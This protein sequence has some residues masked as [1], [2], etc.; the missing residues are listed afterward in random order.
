MRYGSGTRIK[1]LEAFAHRI[2]VVSTTVGA[3]GLDVE[4]ERELL[5]ADDPAEF[6][7]ACISVLTDDDLRRRLVVNGHNRWSINHQVDVL[8]SG[9][10]A[11]A[12]ELQPA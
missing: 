2:P 10:T 3:E 11:I 5:L 12:R 6:A 8:R 4:H 1:I 9:V 7:S